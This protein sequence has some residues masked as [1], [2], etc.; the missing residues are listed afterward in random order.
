LDNKEKLGGRPDLAWEPVEVMLGAAETESEAA[1]K[2][3]YRLLDRSDRRL[4]PLHDPL[5]ANLGLHRWLSKKREEAYSDWLHWV[6]QRLETDEILLVLGVSDLEFAQKCRANPKCDRECVI[7]E[8]RLDLIIRFG[9]DAL[10]VIEVKK[11]SAE[12]ADTEKQKGYT[13][14]AEN[15]GIPFKL[16]LLVV[17]ASDEDY[18][19]FKP[20]LWADFCIALRRILRGPQGQGDGIRTHGIVTAAMFVAFISAIERNLLGL[21]LPDEGR[22]LFYARTADHIKRSLDEE[23]V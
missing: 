7:E 4:D 6:L 11:T 5:R 15:Q 22:T 2:E 19:G 17:D 20:Q 12:G 1:K 13:K 8:G 21:V 3:L 10:I 9:N 18:H 23:A 14:W 16:V